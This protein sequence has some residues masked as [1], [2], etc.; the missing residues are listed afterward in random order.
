MRGYAVD[1]PNEGLNKVSKAYFEESVSRRL[2]DAVH[3]DVYRGLVELLESAYCSQ[4]D[5]LASNLISC[6]DKVAERA[7]AVTDAAVDAAVA[8][9]LARRLEVWRE[10]I[11]HSKVPC[12]RGLC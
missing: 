2:R 3:A 4:G 9:E 6:V 1:H 10:V 8:D 7:A 12:S 11:V 5:W